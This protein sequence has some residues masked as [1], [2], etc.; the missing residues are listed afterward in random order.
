MANPS[1]HQSAYPE[2]R[3]GGFS[4]VDGTVA[5]YT[6]VRALVQPGM[7][8]LDVGCGRGKSVENAVPFRRD[9]RDLRGLGDHV[10]G[11]DVDPGAS[12]NPTLDEFRLMEDI[13]NWPVEDAS[14]DLILS[15]YVLEH[16]EDPDAY[17]RELQRV[18]KPGGIFCARTPNKL[19]YVALVAQV[20]PNHLHAKVVGQTQ[21]NRESHDVFPTFY[22]MNTVGAVKKALGPAFETEVVR[23]AGEPTYFTFSPLAYRF[24][25]V[26]HRMLPGPLQNQFFVFARKRR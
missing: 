3:F 13:E 9:L 2:A 18:L 20:V 26:M 12:E 11:I 10:L 24:G 17:V 4:R 16:V 6:R 21:E 7:K 14:I 23:H 1:L 19:G 15:D 8:V 22:K 5:F 25:A